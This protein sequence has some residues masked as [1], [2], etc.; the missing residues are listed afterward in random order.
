MCECGTRHAP[1]FACSEGTGPRP[2]S[3]R[4]WLQYASTFTAASALG[5]RPALADNP[6]PRTP[7][8]TPAQALQRLQ[9]G[10][11]RY[12]TG[13]T[14]PRDSTQGRAERTRGQWPYAAVLA[15]ADSRVPPELVFDAEEG[16]LFSVRL[17]GNFASPEAL[18][19]LEYAVHVLQVP[20]L[21]V[22]GHSQCGAIAATLHML[23]SGATLPGHLPRLTQAIAPALQGMPATGNTPAA[24]RT[25]DATAL[26][27]QY[28]V[29]QL[30]STSPLLRPALDSSSLRI[31]G[32]VL[33]IATGRV[34]WL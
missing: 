34:N 26:N 5:F 14:Q 8:P 19:S 7:R 3:R 33:D 23:Q 17:A 4:Q 16:E 18:A 6:A 30:Q 24:Q 32:S 9:Q 29:A 12:V 13:N 31:Q 1:S 15:C 11:T 20:L 22:M 28:N 25:A 2:A 21:V 10:N 27:V